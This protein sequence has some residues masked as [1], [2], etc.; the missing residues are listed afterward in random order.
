MLIGIDPALSGPLLKILDE[1]GH[2]DQLVIADRNYPVHSSGKPV[3]RMGDVGVL[4]TFR[5]I[6]SVFP[7]DTYVSHPL[8][9]MEVENDPTLLAPIQL[10]VLDFVRDNHVPDIEFGVIPR[11]DFYERARSVFAVIH[12]LEAEP[13]G[14][15]ILTKGVV[16]DPDKLPP[17]K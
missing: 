10:Q 6:L 4:R 17:K 8:E 11:L 13:Y 15:F 7:L 16:F 1:M 2:G 12:T 5:A 9:R 3:V 14:C